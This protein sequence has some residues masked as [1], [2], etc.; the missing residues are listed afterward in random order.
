MGG[1]PGMLNEKIG[2]LLDGKGGN[3]IFPFFWQHGESEEVLREYMKVIHESN[4]GAVCVESRPH[5]DFCGEK[6]WQD[7]DVILDEARKRGMKVWILDDS[8]F[9]TGFANGAM[10]DR[11]DGLCRQSICCRTYDLKGR[12]SIHI[13]KEEILHPE[14]FKKS[15]IE[16]YVMEKEPRVFDDD[17]LLSVYAM[18]VEREKTDLAESVEGEN[19]VC[20]RSEAENTACDKTEAGN[21][22]CEVLEKQVVSGF[23][24]PDDRMDLRQY[25]KEDG[26]DWTAP[27]GEWRIYVLHLSRNHG[28]HR[29]YINMMDKE[30]CRVLIDAVYE[31]HYAHYKDDFGTT[32]AGFFSDEPELGNGHLYEMDDGFG[33]QSDYPWSRELEEVLRGKLG[34][35][36]E[37][38]MPLLWETEA[39][40]EVT[41]K[42][43]YTYMD[44]VTNLVKEDFSEQIGSW[45][46]E[47]G[48]KY[49]GHLIEDDNH[50]ARTGSSLGHYFRGLAGQDMSGI[51]DIGGQVF[52][53]G[54]DISYNQGGFAHRNGEF[55]HY[56]LGKLGSSAA[57][58]EPGKCG[59]S[60]CEIFGN[61]G[62]S[63][64]VRLEKYLADHFLVRGINHYV[65][66]AFTAKDYPDPDCPPHFYAHGNNPQYRHFGYLMAYMNR[67]CELITDG[68]HAAPVAVLYHGEGDWTGK[69]M[70]SDKVGHVLAD[71]QIEY[72][73]IPQDVFADREGF[74]TEISEG[75]LKV[76]TQT[77]R[78]VLVP[79][80]Q[81]ITKAFADAVDEMQK[82]GV[83]VLFVDGVPEGLCDAPI[84]TKQGGKEESDAVT[85]ENKS[86]TL[87]N[88]KPEEVCS[89]D[90][91]PEDVRLGDVK[92]ENVRSEDVEPEDVKLGDVKS[93]NI[94]LEDI[95]LENIKLGDV[96][97]VLRENRIPE[98]TLNPSNNRIRYYHYIHRDGT[99]VYLFVNEG[100]E[101]YKGDAVL[102]SDT[103]ADKKKGAESGQGSVG[104][105]NVGQ[106]SAGK[107]SVYRYDAWSNRIRRAEVTG[108]TIH[109]E[110]EPLKSEIY[111]FDA[112]ASPEE[113]PGQQEKEIQL[114]TEKEALEFTGTWKRS[115]C[116]SISYPQFEKEKEIT[117]PDA[118]EK[119][120]PEFSG[121]VHYENTFTANAGDKVYVEITDAHEG[122]EVFVNGKSLG[123]QIVPVFNFDL[124][125]A[126][127][128]GENRIRIEVATTLERENAK[129]RTSYMP[130]K[131]PTALSGITGEVKLWKVVNNEVD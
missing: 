93:E 113:I 58:I 81:Y 98:L 6:W 68:R 126:I 33:C 61:Y 90:I 1:V 28:Y 25:I 17:R 117:L 39:D 50:H 89:E 67:V 62:W 123:I 112:C 74:R 8:H 41:A 46:R 122:V 65:P 42:L 105:G 121:F 114:A 115:I 79:Y 57:A 22:T 128:N 101:V 100:T 30:S 15:M 66:H 78:A 130:P 35:D 32:I 96:V 45:C 111:I 43:R 76:N 87:K 5:P 86:G 92:S 56:M 116:R 109:L 19:T 18:R 59:N 23:G 91:Q 125:N 21:D 77:Y 110:I 20:G 16:E 120:E 119:E 44:A 99:S 108:N 80:M 82:K 84:I 83:L 12:E 55:Y 52:P 106:G 75:C 36:F 14:L 88:A 24:N 9:P 107:S 131:D 29:S 13:G 103:G 49:I 37:A 54:E 94:K 64:G 97:S 38:L 7:M 72:D 102:Q 73:F 2:K 129:I 4:I 63:E 104:Q 11:P 60:M 47:R 127:M 34:A 3:Y 10:A 118:L 95:K 85:A 69:H 31:P 48:V 40:A 51:D 26:L 124:S 71:T 70:T 27:E 53:Q